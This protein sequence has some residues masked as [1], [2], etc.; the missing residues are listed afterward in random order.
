MAGWRRIAA[1]LVAP[2]HCLETGDAFLV[3]GLHGVGLQLVIALAQLQ[4]ASGAVPA[5]LLKI[6]VDAN[7]PASTQLSR[8]TFF[9]AV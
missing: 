7:S 9:E 6:T 5:A 4:Q 3:E 8:V 1:S 2:S